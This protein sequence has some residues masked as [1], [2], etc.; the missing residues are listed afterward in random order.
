MQDNEQYFLARVGL[1][2]VD[3]TL[4]FLQLLKYINS[5]NRVVVVSHS[6]GNL[7]A[8][9]VYKMLIQHNSSWSNNIGLIPV[10]TP[11]S[12]VEDNSPY[13]TS[14][15]DIIIINAAIAIGNVLTPNSSPGIISQILQKE[16]DPL[17][18]SFINYYLKIPGLWDAISNNISARISQLVYPNC[19]ANPWRRVLPHDWSDVYNWVNA[20]PSNTVTRSIRDD[21]SEW[22]FYAKHSSG[23]I[24]ISV[25][26]FDGTV[27]GALTPILLPEPFG[28]FVPIPRGVGVLSWKQNVTG[29]SCDNYA[30]SSGEC[31][32]DFVELGTTDVTLTSFVWNQSVSSFETSTQTIT[33]P[34][35]SI[36]I[37]TDPFAPSPSPTAIISSGIYYSSGA[38]EPLSI[39]YAPYRSWS[40]MTGS[41]GPGVSK[42]QVALIDVS[43]GNLTAKHIQAS[44]DPFGTSQVVVPIGPYTSAQ[45]TMALQ[46][47]VLP[48]STLFYSWVNSLQPFPPIQKWFP[49][50]F[51]Q[52]IVGAEDIPVAG[53]KFK[54]APGAFDTSY[55]AGMLN[56][57]AFSPP[58]R[59][60]EKVINQ[61]GTVT[62][63]FPAVLPWVIDLDVTAESKAFFAWKRPN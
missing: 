53:L 23:I 52:R 34:P 24:S 37:I 4:I 15:S 39:Q 63:M 62:T 20:I 47:P 10:A 49:Y 3:T 35:Y 30:N 56:R 58:A 13:V 36:E 45:M 2:D 22:Q 60:P 29:T 17:G 21:V 16:V 61:F 40:I 59:V 42:T 1:Y 28:Q 19:Q 8:N 48:G 44:G 55:M 54:T 51:D 31:F 11:A 32:A 27:Y 12:V 9:H 26:S 46:H 25:E 7:Y 14:L 38:R 5:G 50:L 41:A 6:E 18:H 33:L 57:T 43:A